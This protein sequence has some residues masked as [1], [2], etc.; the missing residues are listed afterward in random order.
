MWMYVCVH[1]RTHT[2]CIDGV[3]SVS[4]EVR[5]RHLEGPKN[6]DGLNLG[7]HIFVCV[8]KVHKCMYMLRVGMRSWIKCFFLQ[9][10]FSSENEKKKM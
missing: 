10:I 8:Y 2:H 7:T 1:A 6:P 5:M 9:Y 3:L 4:P